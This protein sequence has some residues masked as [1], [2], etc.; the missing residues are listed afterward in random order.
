MTY[1]EGLMYASNQ[2]GISPSWLDTVIQSE[3]KGD[4]QAV[5]PSS[6][7]TG[8]IQFMPTTAAELGT[9]IDKIYNMNL[10]E[11]FNL[12]VKYFQLQMKYNNITS[13]QRD[14]DTYTLVFYP[15][16]V[17]MPL[18]YKLP[19]NVYSQNYKM[20]DSEGK[21][22]INV[23]DIKQQFEKIYKYDYA[24]LDEIA[25]N[26]PTAAMEGVKSIGQFL[27]EN[28]KKVVLFLLI[29]LLYLISKAV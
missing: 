26:L 28:P 23:N 6:N 4:L 9:T 12:I 25:G 8:L 11:Q 29:I 7:A 20:F 16:A 27:A 3:S 21:G 15:K 18:E 2:L 14:F 24:Y 19:Q 22:Y 17:N 10:E 13:I 5:N 1:Q